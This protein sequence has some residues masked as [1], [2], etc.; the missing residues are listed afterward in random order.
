MDWARIG[1]LMLGRG[2]V[3]GRLGPALGRAPIRPG[4]DV[5]FLVNT[6]IRGMRG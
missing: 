1:M 5:S 6:A 2:E 4:F 3:N